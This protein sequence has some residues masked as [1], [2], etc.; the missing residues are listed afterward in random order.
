MNNLKKM[1]F[2]ILIVLGFVLIFAFVTTL[3]SGKVSLL[4]ENDSST[5]KVVSSKFEKFTLSELKHDDIEFINQ[6]SNEFKVDNRLIFALIKQESQFD[7][8]A[9]SD[10][11]AVGLMQIM[12][13]TN[14]EVNEELHIENAP[15]LKGHLRAGIYYF[16]KL[17]NLFKNGSS[18]DRLRL[19]LAAYNAG[20]SRIYDAQELVAYLNENPN[21]W[22]SIRN[23]LPLLSKRYYSLHQSVW[24]GG[25][26]KNGYFGSSR[27][28]IMFVE[29]IMRIY[30]EFRKG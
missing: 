4:S 17:L 29:N 7:K 30:G 28:T 11:G 19:A 3:S 2:S 16:S 1:K 5:Q 12:P 10:R 13:A 20:P 9:L 21:S 18:D 27:Q 25:K 22:T 8:E 14:L 24:E 26:P 15:L 23:A 6:F